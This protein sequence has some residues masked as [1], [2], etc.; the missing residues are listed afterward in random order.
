MDAGT[1]YNL[2]AEEREA[3]AG[4]KREEHQ[5]ERGRRQPGKGQIRKVSPWGKGAREAGAAGF[6]AGS[7]FES[8]N[9]VSPSLGVLAGLS[10]PG[11]SK[12]FSSWLGA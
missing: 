4:I 7:Y 5:G 11:M 8:P 12:L 9:L 10:S 3:V 2:L 6:F 1:W